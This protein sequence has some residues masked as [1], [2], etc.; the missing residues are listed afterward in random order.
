MTC[1]LIFQLSIAQEPSSPFSV[2]ENENNPF[3]NEEK[4]LGLTKE[5]KKESL[6]QNIDED[7]DDDYNVE[8]VGFYSN[9]PIKIIKASL[10]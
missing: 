4:G 10:I 5:T 2:R 7:D 1:Q 3:K 9:A 6:F 8:D